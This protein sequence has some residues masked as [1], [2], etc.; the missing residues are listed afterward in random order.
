MQ[1]KCFYR[2]WV[3]T[4]LRRLFQVDKN[5]GGTPITLIDGI[6]GVYTIYQYDAE[7]QVTND[8]TKI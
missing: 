8:T 2:Y 6:T 3:D 1:C 7:A 5:N 4:K